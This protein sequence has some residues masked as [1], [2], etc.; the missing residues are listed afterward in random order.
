MSSRHRDKIIAASHNTQNNGYLGCV[1]ER[2]ANRCLK[3]FEFFL[4]KFFL[5]FQI[6]L[7]CYIKTNF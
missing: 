4:N 6:I 5:Y 3:N 2:G 7:I 1:W